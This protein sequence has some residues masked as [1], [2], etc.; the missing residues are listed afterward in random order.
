MRL[1]VAA[2]PPPAVVGRLALLERPGA[3]GLR[4]TTEDQWH[5]TLR[6]FGDIGGDEVDGVKDALGHLASDEQI[7]PLIA[8][9]GPAVSRLGS[10]VLCVPVSGLD[11]L[12]ASIG[13]L[14]AHIGAPAGSR[15][16]HG[17]LTLARLKAGAPAP[18]ANVAFSAD[19]PV[20]EV[21]LV[22]SSLHP[23]GARYEVISRVA[24]G[25]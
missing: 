20:D 1:F 15:G 3:P 18:L 17:H 8:V 4:W 23:G 12:A 2:W 14:T 11:G 22:A 10:S 6:F 9:A 24:V 5:V 13:R 21:T 25:R 7:G 19:W 16:F